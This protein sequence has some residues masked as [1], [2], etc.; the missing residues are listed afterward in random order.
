[1]LEERPLDLSPTGLAEVVDLLHAAFPDASHLDVRYLH[2]C[3]CANPAGAAIGRN[4]YDEG[5][6][7]A[8]YVTVPLRARILGREETG[9]LSLHTATHPEHQGKGLFTRLAEATYRDAAAAGHGF[10]LG[11]ANAASTPGF[12]RKLG[13][14]LVHPLDVRI[15]LGAAPEPRGDVV[16]T[17]ERLWD[18]PSL[19]WRLACPAR[20]YRRVLR[21]GRA[22][23]YAPTGRLGIWAELAT[24]SRHLAATE[25]LPR[26]GPA[27]PLRLWMGL[28]P[29][30]RWQGAPWM[31]LPASL[32]P[33]PLNLIF[34]DLGGES[35]VLD[36][37]SVRFAA[38]D[39]D[40]Y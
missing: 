25:E 35:R 2:W 27:N 4:A 31:R 15:G 26:L 5:R 23:V 1:M 40:A 37:A 36:A 38:F 14:Q 32:R 6:L 18:E 13:F 7:A 33:S 22:T 11:V 10:V 24:V 12:V 17:F 39:F 8:H 34:R 19:R 3:Y 21:R 29:G 28:D 16:V 20:L 9:V 30:R